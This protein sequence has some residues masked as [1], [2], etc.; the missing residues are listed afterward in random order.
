[1]VVSSILSSL[2]NKNFKKSMRLP[3][4]WGK[5]NGWSKITHTKH[6]FLMGIITNQWCARVI[7]VCVRVTITSSQS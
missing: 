6:K 5:E 1:V 2:V 7:F 4:F 3:Q